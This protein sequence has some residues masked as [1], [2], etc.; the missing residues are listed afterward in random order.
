MDRLDKHFRRLTKNVFARY[1]F[2]YAGVLSEWSAI[3]GEELGRVSVPE[4]IRWPRSTGSASDGR[5]SGGTIVVRVAEGRALEFQHLAPRL[6]ERIN[7]YYGFEAV[8][9]VKVVQGTVAAPA[10]QSPSAPCP[11]I[12]REAVSQRV[13]AIDDDRL[14]AALLRLGTS[15][16]RSDRALSPTTS[17]TR[18]QS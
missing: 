4:R 17:K 6:I 18:I 15:V 14:R 13:A 16:S 8:A 12:R 5:K 7:R 2:A 9:G 1:G 11:D 3:V 10:S